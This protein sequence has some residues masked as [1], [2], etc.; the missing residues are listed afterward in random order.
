[1]NK[2]LCRTLCAILPIGVIAAAYI[3]VPDK[4]TLTENAQYSA[5]PNGL[6]RLS[7]AEGAVIDTASVGVQNVTAELFGAVPIKNVEVSVVPETYVYASGEAIGVRIYSD[8]IMVVGVETVGGARIAGIK[9]GDII[10][11]INGVAAESTEQLAA[12]ISAK[13]TNTLTVRRDSEHLTFTVR[14]QKGE[15]GYT[16][17]MWIRDSAAGIGTLTYTTDD[18]SFG[19][20]GHSICDSD[21]ELTVPLGHGSLSPCRITSVKKGKSGEPGELVGTICGEVTGSVGANCELGLFGTLSKQ[22]GGRKLPTATEF[23][24]KEGDAEI[25]CNIDGTGVK[26]YKIKIEQL[27]RSGTK[28]NKNMSIRVVDETLL[29]ATGGIVQGMSGSPIIQNG[30]IV[31]AV[32]HVF[33]NDPTRGYGIFIENMLS[34][35]E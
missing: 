28:S 31:G 34:A 19:A 3:S 7:S 35:A 26:A 30:R 27:Y 33:V 2:N 21:T 32:T 25:L 23:L 16:V 9:K 11:K 22:I 13:K 14:G 24:I 18:Y 15:N 29:D 6:V 5:Y 8:G 12:A 4:I 20:L 10:E 1:M 17:G